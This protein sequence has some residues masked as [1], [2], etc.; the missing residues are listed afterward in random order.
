VKREYVDNYRKSCIAEANELLELDSCKRL[1]LG[2]LKLQEIKPPKRSRSTETLERLPG[3]VK[4]S[5]KRSKK[6]FMLQRDDG[7]DAVVEFDGNKFSVGEE[8]NPV[9]QSLPSH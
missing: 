6:K 8:F 3:L 5:D 1:I 4:K 2:V 7:T 9:F